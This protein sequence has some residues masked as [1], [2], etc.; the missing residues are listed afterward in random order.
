RVPEIRWRCTPGVLPALAATQAA[1]LR[2]A[3]AGGVPGGRLIYATCSSEPEE[4]EAV[5]E[6]LLA[7]GAPFAR[8]RP[9][10]NAPSQLI[11]GQ[12][13]LRTLPHRDGLEAFFAAVLRRN[14]G[15]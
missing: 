5:V 9:A 2:A 4:N 6:R 11:D 1:L 15:A 8:E 3:A 10:G 12:G 7:G 13:Q 14:G